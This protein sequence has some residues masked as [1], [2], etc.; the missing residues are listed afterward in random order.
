LRI[1]FAGLRSFGAVLSLRRISARASLGLLVVSSCSCKSPTEVAHTVKSQ[2][3]GPILSK[4][5]KRKVPP[6]VS[7]FLE[8]RPFWL[9]FGIG[10]GI[11]LLYG[12][13]IGRPADHNGFRYLLGPLVCPVP[14]FLFYVVRPFNPYRG[15][16]ARFAGMLDMDKRDPDA[17]QLVQLFRS[18]QA[19]NFLVRATVKLSAILFVVMA[20]ITVACRNSLN[21]LVVSPWFGQGLT[22]GLIACLVTLGSAYIAWGLESWAKQGARH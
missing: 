8:Q 19:R 17:Q 7:M 3:N 10:L 6:F 4:E 9:L 12:P 1:P 14:S 16:A 22:G 15:P 13:V 18:D 21:W 5:L 11:F 2:P 20:V